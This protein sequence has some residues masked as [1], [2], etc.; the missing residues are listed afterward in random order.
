MFGFQQKQNYFNLKGNVWAIEDP[1]I[2][3]LKL[4]MPIYLTAN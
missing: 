1:L 2:L 4:L 3:G